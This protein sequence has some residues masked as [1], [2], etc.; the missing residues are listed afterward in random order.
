M[1]LNNIMHHK[2]MKYNKKVIYEL[3]FSIFLII[4]IFFHKYIND[5]KKIFL[6]YNSKYTFL[7][8][9]ASCMTIFFAVKKDSLFVGLCINQMEFSMMK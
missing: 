5:M 9:S 3:T 8:N 7:H 6:N 2:D 1:N 4:I